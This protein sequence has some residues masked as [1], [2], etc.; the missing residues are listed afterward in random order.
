MMLVSVVAEM[1]EEYTVVLTRVLEH[2][3]NEVPLPR[4][5]RFLILRHLPFASL[6]LNPSLLPPPP[7]HA[8]APSLH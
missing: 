8:S 5:I 7:H 3:F 4:R 2:L 6:P 1:L